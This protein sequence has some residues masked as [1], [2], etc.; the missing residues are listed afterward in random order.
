MSAST[1]LPVQGRE[2]AQTK[3]SRTKAPN[4]QVRLALILSLGLLSKE[5]LS[6]GLLFV[7]L[8]SGIRGEPKK[9]KVALDL[10]LQRS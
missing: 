9:H 7:G 1:S 8:S 3:A 6:M 5:L 2:G 4:I 10:M